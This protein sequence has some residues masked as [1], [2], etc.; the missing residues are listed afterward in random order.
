MLSATNAAATYPPAC[1]TARRSSGLTIT[2]VAP[3]ICR[4]TSLTAV[5]SS[6]VCGLRISTSLSSLPATSPNY[7]ARVGALSATHP[8]VGIA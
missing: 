6:T 4:S 2:E 1:S 8:L 7:C 5:I 3:Q